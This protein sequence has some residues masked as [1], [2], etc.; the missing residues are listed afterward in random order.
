MPVGACSERRRAA[1][2]MLFQLQ[3]ERG[4]RSAMIRYMAAALRVEEKCSDEE[5]KMVAARG[6]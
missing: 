2:A 6:G 1:A 5:A 4:V 3:I